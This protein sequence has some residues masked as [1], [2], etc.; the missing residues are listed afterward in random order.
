MQLRIGVFGTFHPE[1]RYAGNSTTPIVYCLSE[2][3][4]IE[5]V[6][7]FCQEGASLP[8]PDKQGKIELVPCWRHDDWFSLVRAFFRV[9][10]LAQTLDLLVFNTYV[11]GYGKKEFANVAGLLL[12]SM[13]SRLS[14][15]PTFVYMHNFAETQ[16]LDKLG[17]SPSLVTR[18]LVASMERALLG[19]ADVFV[20]L[21][22]QAS[23]VASKLGSRPTQL[24]FPYLEGYLQ[25]RSFLAAPETV[26]PISQHEPQILLIGAWGP[27]KDLT[28][29][30]GA[31]NRLAQ[32]GTV[33]HVTIVGGA[34]PRFP[35]YSP[36][37]DYVRY[38]FLSDRVGITGPLSEQDLFET[39]LNHDVS[40]LAYNTTGGYSG[41]LNLVAVTDLPV[42]AYD[43]PQLREQAALI[44]ANVTF[45]SPDGLVDALRTFLNRT[46]GP[47]AIDRGA[48]RQKVAQ[49]QSATTGFVKRVQAKI[50]ESPSR[51]R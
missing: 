8:F 51:R 20:P 27:Q 3:E 33:F 18:T 50:R 42:I 10:G 31:L 46:S 9:L 41:A 38:P 13:I 39:V 15:R 29:A 4:S 40:L 43:R 12:P 44:G 17:Y 30:L 47:R 28:G 37:V 45:V 23:I 48:V 25:A 11:A 34:H 5:R 32:A 49:T 22:S 2:D 7:V 19:T 16:E 35:S 21:A 24:F 1:H 6:T 26:P 36:W 14:R